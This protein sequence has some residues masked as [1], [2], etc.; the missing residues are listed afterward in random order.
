LTF[1]QFCGDS[2]ETHVEERFIDYLQHCF[3]TYIHFVTIGRC[4]SCVTLAKDAR[5]LYTLDSIPDI[6]SANAPSSL[7]TTPVAQATSVFPASSTTP[8]SDLTGSAQTTGAFPSPVAE[9]ME[10]EVLSDTSTLPEIP[11]VGMGDSAS[12]ATGPSTII[13]HSTGSTGEITTDGGEQPPPPSDATTTLVDNPPESLLADADVRP[14]WLMTAIKDFLRYVPYF[15]NLGKAADLWLAQEA[16]LGYPQLVCAFF[17]F[18]NPSL[19]A[20][21]Q[22]VRLALPSRNRPTEVATFMK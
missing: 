4:G 14:D 22:S 19:T 9:T 13:N 1:S 16:R 3:R 20:Q 15:G 17:C 12:S 8:A 11:D 10:D 5:R 7:N 21:S 6:G 18:E 2:Y